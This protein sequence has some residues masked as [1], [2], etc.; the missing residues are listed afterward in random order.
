VWPD[1]K[2]GRERLPRGKAVIDRYPE[3]FGPAA[4][5]CLCNDDDCTTVRDAE[6][7][8]LCIHCGQGFDD[9]RNCYG[10]DYEED[11]EGYLQLREDD[12]HGLHG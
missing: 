3:L 6:V 8:D 5:V 11:D 9:E 4:E 12:G 1:G 7:G 2:R 10:C